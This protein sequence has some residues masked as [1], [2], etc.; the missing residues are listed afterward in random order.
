MK[1]LGHA[2]K[3]DQI[4]REYGI[5]AKCSATA[6]PQANKKLERIHKVIPNV[7]RSLNLQNNYV[8]G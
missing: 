2:F 3:I 7:V 4:E 1:Y 5:K 6:N 8:D